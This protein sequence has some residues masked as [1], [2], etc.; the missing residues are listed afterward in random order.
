MAD[1]VLIASALLL[2][3][4]IAYVL[5]PL[6]GPPCTYE[7]EGTRASRA[8][9]LAAKKAMLYQSL[10]DADLDRETGKLCPVDYEE[11]TQELRAEAVSVMKEL[12]RLPV[13]RPGRARESRG[14]H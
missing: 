11:M 9:A 7:A 2:S 6:F 10:R 4:A 8:G 13:L 5:G 1:A 12:D 14:R 3:S